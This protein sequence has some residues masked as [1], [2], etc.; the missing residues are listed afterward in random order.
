MKIIIDSRMRKIE[1]EY[2]SQYGDLIELPY[3]SSVYEEISSHPDIF[4]CQ[5]NNQ[6][7]Q[8]PN[9]KL[10]N[11]LETKLK[12]KQGSNSVGAQYPEDIKYNI[13]QI[14]KRVIH[15]FKYTDPAVA[16]YID[17]TGIQK[18]N[19]KQGYSKCSISVTSENSCITSDEGICETLKRK[20]ID[21]LLLGNTNI[22]LLDKNGLQT[23]MNG[24]IGGATAVI[25]DKF[26]IF[27]DSNKILDKASLIEHLNN[28]NLKLVDFKN[29]EIIDYGSIITQ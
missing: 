8:A 7:F 20:N 2:L 17:S 19:I 22:R 29:L 3:Q 18:I 23:K 6:I 4:F 21:V 13:C 26:I 14:G 12:T 16:K 11:K 24:F 28:H 5:I 10:E 27:G 1:K 15:N 25:E 9:L